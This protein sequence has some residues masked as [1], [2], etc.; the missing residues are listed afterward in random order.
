MT[1]EARARQSTDALLIA[2]GWAVQ[3]LKR[4]RILGEVVRRL[5]II[6][7]VKADVDANIHSSSVAAA[8]SGNRVVACALG[9]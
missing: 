7:E 8:Y 9:A 3:D 1:P 5:S 6:R 2:A 4:G